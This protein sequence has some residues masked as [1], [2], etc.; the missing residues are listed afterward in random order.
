MR[1]NAGSYPIFAGGTF[2]GITR[3]MAG[4]F[5]ILPSKA[6]FLIGTGPGEIRIVHVILYFRIFSEFTKSKKIVY[7]GNYLGKWHKQAEK[8]RKNPYEIYS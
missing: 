7:S 8:W 2:P 6:F 5:S 3:G 4:I 1:K